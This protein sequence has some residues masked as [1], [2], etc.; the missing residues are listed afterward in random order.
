[1]SVRETLIRNNSAGFASVRKEGKEMKGVFAI[2]SVCVYA[3]TNQNV[4][5]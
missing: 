3:K 1:M 4:K 5:F 2:G